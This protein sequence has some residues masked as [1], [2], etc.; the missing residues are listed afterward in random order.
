MTKTL[1]ASA[2]QMYVLIAGNLLPIPPENHC[3]WPTLEKTPLWN[4]R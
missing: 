3:S 1:G 4:M 2:L